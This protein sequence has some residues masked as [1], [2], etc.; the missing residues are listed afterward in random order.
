M[1][2]DLLDRFDDWVRTSPHAVAVEADGVAI[3]Y[4]A[5]GRRAAVVTRALHDAGCEPGDRVVVWTSDRAVLVSLML[6]VL[7]VGAVFV[8]L[9]CDTPDEQLHQRLRRLC[10][11]VLIHD[12]HVAEVA[13]QHIIGSAAAGC[14]CLAA[15]GDDGVA[16]EAHAMMAHHAAA[17]PA[18]VYFTSGSTG[19]PKGIVGSRAALADRIAW[20]IEAFHVQRG[21][22]V[23][24]LVTPTFDPWFRDIFVPLCSGG[25]IVVPPESPARFE[26]ER[27]LEWL[28]DARIGLMHCGPS[29][30]TAMVSAPA[31]IRRL[32]ALRTVLSSGET[33]HVSLVRRWHRRF[34]KAVQL[35]NLYGPTEATM[36]Q[37]CHQ[38][39]PSDVTRSFIP[40]GFPLPGVK[41]RLI[42]DAGAPCA[43]GEAGEILIGGASLSL[44]YFDDEAETERAFVH[45]AEDQ[46]ILYYRTGDLGVE[47]QPGRY[48][49]LGRIDDQVKIRGVRVE[50][51]EVEDALLGYPL[52]ASCAVAGRPDRNGE[53]SLVAYVVPETQ[54][55]PAV[56]EMRAYLGER[57]PAQ[58]LPTAFVMMKALP[59]SAN[60]KIDR[61][62]LPVP[63]NVPALQ[64]GVSTPP[65]NAFEAALAAHWAEILGLPEVGVEDDF[66]DIGGHS[67]GA[68][69]LLSAVSE[70]GLGELSIRDILEHRTIAAQAA[71]LQ[72]RSIQ[73]PP[74]ENAANAVIAS[75]ATR[76]A[77]AGAAAFGCPRRASPLFGRRDCNLAIV[78]GVDDDR[79]SFERAA[80][81]VSEF[82]PA[83]RTRVV[84]DTPGW[85]VGLPLQPSLVVSPGLLRHRPAMPAHVCCGYPLAKSEEYRIL[86]RAG[87]PVPH[88]VTLE[89][90]KE[91]D[92]SRFGRYVVRKPDYGAKGAEIRI[93]RRNRVR[94][95]S[96]VTSAAGPSPR[97]LVQ[98]FVYT[99]LWPVSYR[100]NTLFGRVLYSLTITGN[101]SRPA[102]KGPEDFD[103]RGDGGQAVSIVA[104]ARDS[105][106]A[107]CMDAEIIALGEHAAG[108]F[109]DVPLLGVDILR[110]VLTGQLLV[111][112]VNSLG[113]N[114]N[115]GPAFFRAF[116][117]DIERQFN[118]LRK[119]AY[120]L[121]EE[122]QRRAGVLPNSARSIDHTPHER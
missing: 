83:V 107:V 97:L 9:E 106:A 29:L 72:A 39:D 56:P 96:V 93:V 104:N 42:D 65:R 59:L 119:A 82:D 15:P 81:M 64:A 20:E 13:R 57:F 112:E 101:Q 99:G 26:P 1:N 114:W 115:F 53:P 46:E 44:G 78:L 79:E 91:P 40:I 37:F 84:A 25:T 90:G 8:P 113:H 63:D 67:L 45:S 34:G 68:M 6:G 19:R 60:G 49:L 94:W 121:A 80:G 122:T 11:R 14:V 71:L 58:Y 17:A 89:E 33:L 22:R 4:R 55:S 108:A 120:I 52:V 70:A 54:Y 5:L 118:G 27:L 32:P 38:V 3:S 41:V 92:L 117:V 111:T 74:N 98:E 30:M 2:F 110:N 86:E 100:V 61:W 105:T 7:R 23:S 85:D 28:R 76:R 50:P 36:F 77:H 12:A 88:W 87:V 31:R 16:I 103:A 116:R 18:Y 43:P 24:Q 69:R 48:R 62:R 102:L 35:V 47:Y 51:R 21:V 109:P 75:L 73:Q 95:R 66:L 10:P